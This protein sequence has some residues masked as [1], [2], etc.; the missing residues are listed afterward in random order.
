M[1]RSHKKLVGNPPCTLSDHFNN[2]ILSYSEN[3]PK[4]KVKVTNDEFGPLVLPE[5]SLT[6]SKPVRI[7]LDDFEPIK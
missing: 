3:E 1:S 6:Q 4:K 7:I 2:E 5:I